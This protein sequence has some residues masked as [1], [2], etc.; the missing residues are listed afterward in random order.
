MRGIVKIITLDD[1]G[2]ANDVGEFLCDLSLMNSMA[3]AIAENNS[4]GY[5]MNVGS[6]A[7]IEDSLIFSGIIGETV[8][9]WHFSPP[10][11]GK[12]S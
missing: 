11:M 5:R 7:V 3:F 9:Q 1:E 4:A 8:T 12:V 2:K 6:V 10:K